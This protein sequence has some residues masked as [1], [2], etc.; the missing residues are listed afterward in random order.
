MNFYNFLPERKFQL[1]KNY[2]AWNAY[3]KDNVNLIIKRTLRDKNHNRIQEEDNTDTVKIYMNLKFSVNA[4][5]RHIKKC[6]KNF[7]QCFKREI[8]VKLV[9]HYEAKQNYFTKNKD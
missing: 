6:T 8:T 2:A 7:Y 1:I 3:S 9:L 4:V 5:N